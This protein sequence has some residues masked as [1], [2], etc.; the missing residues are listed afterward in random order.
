MKPSSPAAP[1]QVHYS[2]PSS[3]AEFLFWEKLYELKLNKFG[4]SGSDVDEPIVSFYQNKTITLTDNSFVLRNETKDQ[5]SHS[6]GHLRNVNTINV[7]TFSPHN[8][9]PLTFFCL[10]L[11]SLTL[12]ISVSVSVSLCVSLSLSSTP[13]RS[14]S[15]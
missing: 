8:A 7:S 5:Q 13:L 1:R 2:P 4:L 3:C 10:S 14:S 11:P 9:H 12:Y 15:R 6:L